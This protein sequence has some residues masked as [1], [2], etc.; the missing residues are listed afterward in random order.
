MEQPIEDADKIYNQKLT[1]VLNFFASKLQLYYSS[2]RLTLLLTFLS[3]SELDL[4]TTYVIPLPSRLT[5]ADDNALGLHSAGGIYGRHFYWNIFQDFLDSGDPLALDK[6]R[7]TIASLACLKILFGR[8]QAPVLRITWFSR[9]SR[10]L[11]ADMEDDSQRH[12]THFPRHTTWGRSIRLFWDLWTR[13][14]NQIRQGRYSSDTLNEQLEHQYFRSKQ[15]QFLLHKSAYSDKIIDF[16]R[17]RVFRCAYLARQHPVY[18]KKAIFSLAKYIQ[19]VTGETAEV[20]A[21]ESIWG[22]DRWFT[23]TAQ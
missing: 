8:Y 21:C 6:R 22:R 15:L 23:A 17:Y 4:L 2:S 5:I 7:Y 12:Y 9:H 1:I 3:A 13:L 11:R 14:P 18:M 10:T 19:R 16:A 20:R